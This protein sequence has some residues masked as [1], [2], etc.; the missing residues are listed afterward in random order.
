LAERYAQTRKLFSNSELLSNLG[1]G[2]RAIYMDAILEPVPRR[3]A[4]L[5]KQMIE[6]QKNAR[7][8]LRDR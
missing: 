3:C 6:V 2:L 8:K 1:K 4:A 7:H 5:L